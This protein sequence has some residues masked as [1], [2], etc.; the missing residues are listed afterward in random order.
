MKRLIDEFRISEFKPAD[1]E[2]K[3][4]GE[5][6]DI[7]AY[8][9]QISDTETVSLIGSV[10]RVDT[11]VKEGNK[12]IR[13]VDYKTQGKE[14]KLSDVY[15]GLNMQM[16]LYLSAINE[17]GEERY[18]E[19]KKYT[20]IP[21]GIM[22]MPATPNSKT[23]ESNSKENKTES[24]KEQ[25]RNFKASGLFLNDKNVLSAMEKELQGMYIPVKQK[26]D[27]DFDSNSLKRLVTKEQYEQIFSYIKSKMIAMVVSL[28]DGK[29]ERNP[30]KGISDACKFCD[31]QKVCGYEDGKQ[32]NTISKYPIE[33]TLKMMKETLKNDTDE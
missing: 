32:S 20:L 7:P 29:I 25:T 26:K 16:L 15:Y 27:G 33:E 18:S 21:A 17:N 1:E 24:S 11:Y 14:F 23:K 19:E 9:L 10:D 31:Y 3:I 6:A 22:Y 30:A 12:Y 28:M 8:T 13:I 5:N 2:L 4:G